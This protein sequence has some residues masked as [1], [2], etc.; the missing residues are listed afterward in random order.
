VCIVSGIIGEFT[1][2]AYISEE[3][4]S[5]GSL[6]PSLSLEATLETCHAVPLHIHYTAFNPEMFIQRSTG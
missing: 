1:E 2:L 5:I 4:Q 6:V 3:L